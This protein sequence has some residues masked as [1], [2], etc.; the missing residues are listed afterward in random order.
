MGMAEVVVTGLGMVTPLGCG[1]GEV[2]DRILRGERAIQPAPFAPPLACR[3]FAPVTD[4]DAGLLF[5]DNKTLRLMNRDA[6]MA[7]V[8]A[9][10]AMGD[11]GIVPG[12]LYAAEEIAL[13]GATG[14][15]GMPPAEIAP[16]IEHAAAADGSLDLRRFG[17]AALRRIRP[18]LSFKILANMPIC[19]V[20]IFENLRGP[21]AVYTPW[22]GHGAQAIAAGVRAVASGEV[23]CAVVGGCDVK[24]HW[25]SFISLQQLGCFDGWTQHGV[26]TA[27]GEGACFLVLEDRTRAIGRGARVYASLRARAARSMGAGFGLADVMADVL[28]DVLSKV[29]GG[30]TGTPKPLVVAAGDEDREFSQAECE[31]MDEVVPD[32]QGVL[33][34]KTH[35]GNLFACAAAVQVALAAAWAARQPAGAP[36]VANCFGPGGEQ[37]AFAVEAL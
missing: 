8:A 18:V 29:T 34:P 1:A 27:P 6:Q 35:L 36:V 21:N 30:L 26:G 3:Q 10:L 20:S 33:R 28:G 4:F 14:L 17:Q 37:A 2:L 23:P 32:R 13:Y 9:R 11:A 24:T 16:L 22:E 25:L 15:S 12:A 19:F 5:P 31:A 7:V